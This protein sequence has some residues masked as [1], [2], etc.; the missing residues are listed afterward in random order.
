MGVGVAIYYTTLNQETYCKTIGTRVTGTPSSTRAELWAILLALKMLPYDATAT[1]F[2]DSQASIQ[3]I[4][5]FKNTRNG[6]R[7]KKYKNPYVLQVI[8]DLMEVKNLKIDFVKIKA[9]SGTLGNDVADKLAKWGALQSE[10]IQLN[11][12]LLTNNTFHKW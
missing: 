3:A 11:Y 2:T 4:K 5:N 6:L 8:A 9:H 12:S 1:I 7:W 10:E